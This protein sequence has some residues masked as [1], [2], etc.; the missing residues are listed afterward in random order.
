[1]FQESQFDFKVHSK[2][3]ATGLG[4]LT[5]IA[6]RQLQINRQSPSTEKKLQA[7]ISHLAKIYKDPIFK[8]VLTEMGFKV[9]FP[10][11]KQFPKAIVSARKANHIF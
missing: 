10:E 3:G 5:G 7:T 2:T 11:L 1:M 8:E 4:Q 6:I 9:E